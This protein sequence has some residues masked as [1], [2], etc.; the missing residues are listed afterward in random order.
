M[1]GEALLVICCGIL[2]AGVELCIQWFHTASLP[3]FCARLL[4]WVRLLPGYQILCLQSPASASSWHEATG[5]PHPSGCFCA[6]SVTP[7][8]QS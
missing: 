7:W 2:Y 8:F 1:M 4:L 3:S 6:V 5:T